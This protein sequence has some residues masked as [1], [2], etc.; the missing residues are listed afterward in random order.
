MLRLEAPRNIPQITDGT[1]STDELLEIENPTGWVRSL[2]HQQEQAKAD[3]QQ[4]W[5]LSGSAL[6]RMN[7]WIRNIERAYMTLAQGTQYI[8]DQ[9]QKQENF[10]ESWLRNELAATANVKI[11]PRLLRGARQAT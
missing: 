2:V 10:T 6:D 11:L 5:E 8:Y 4:L 1:E 3:L 9:I 7:R